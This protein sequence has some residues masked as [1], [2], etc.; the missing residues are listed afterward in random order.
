MLFA[1][2]AA[3]LSSLGVLAI[4]TRRPPAEYALAGAQ[5]IT[6]KT[7]ASAAEFAAL[8]SEWDALH[9]DAPAATV[10]NSWLWQ[11]RWWELYGADQPLR[12]LV[13]VQK[14]VIVGILPLYIRKAAVARLGVKELRAVGTGG[15][16]FP[17]DL[18]PVI[19]RFA[20]EAAVLQALAE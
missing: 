4:P 2:S 15:D 12:V 5:Q 18:G 3:L 11:Y 19:S 13:A 20:P 17:D 9:D 1:I 8:Q 7:V 16:T 6:V 10:F 14:G